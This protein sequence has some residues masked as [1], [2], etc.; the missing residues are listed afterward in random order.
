MQVSCSHLYGT[1]KLAAH[2]LGGPFWD[3]LLV[4]LVQLNSTTM[5]I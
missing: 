3:V 1:P 5:E 2:S 4:D